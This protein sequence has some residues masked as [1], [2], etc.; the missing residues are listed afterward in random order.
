MDVVDVAM[1]HVNKV[2][3]NAVVM[4][5]LCCLVQPQWTCSKGMSPSICR[6]RATY[7]S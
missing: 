7:L 4:V 3:V 5:A 2:E 1:A 6:L